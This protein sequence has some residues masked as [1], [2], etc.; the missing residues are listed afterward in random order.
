M[1]LIHT[2]KVLAKDSRNLNVKNMPHKKVADNLLT[3]GLIPSP[4]VYFKMQLQRGFDPILA[5]LNCL[6]MLCTPDS[7]GMFVEETK[8]NRL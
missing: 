3:D 8:N 5:C 6:H 2:S 4:R 7:C 1:F